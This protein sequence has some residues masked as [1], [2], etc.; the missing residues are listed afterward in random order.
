VL[1]VRTTPWRL[2]GNRTSAL[3]GVVSFTFRPL[4]PRERAPYPLNMRLGGIQSRSRCGGEERNSCTSRKPN[5]GHPARTVV[6]IL[7]RL[8]WLLE[9]WNNILRPDQNCILPHVIIF[10]TLYFGFIW[11]PQLMGLKLTA[12]WARKQKHYTQT[13]TPIAIG[14]VK[15]SLGVINFLLD[16]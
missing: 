16:L 6:T 12:E 2:K 4:Y 8:S 7:T 1:K 10:S 9:Y 14:K 15:Q 5:P 13:V 3:D 11:P